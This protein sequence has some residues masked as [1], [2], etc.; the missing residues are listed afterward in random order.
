MVSRRN[1]QRAPW[2]VPQDQIAIAEHGAAAD[3]GK[4]A[5]PVPLQRHNSIMKSCSPSP[6]PSKENGDSGVEKEVALKVIPKKKVK[7]NEE[8]V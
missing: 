5:I 1:V 8:G 3:L 6:T 7:E 2:H 4:D